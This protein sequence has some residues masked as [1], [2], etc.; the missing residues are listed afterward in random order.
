MTQR[1]GR[2]K[3]RAARAAVDDALAQAASYRQAAQDANDIANWH[4]RRHDRAAALLGEVVERITRAVTAESALLPVDVMPARKSRRE[5]WARNHPL[6]RDLD[7]F[8]AMS[9][10]AEPL[11]LDMSE[12]FVRLQRLVATVEQH[13]DQFRTLIRFEDYEDGGPGKI[14]GRAVW[15]SRD[16]LRRI[17]LMGGD[18]LRLVDDIAKQLIELPKRTT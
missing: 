3:R 13:P 9:A 1:F 2:N 12:D 7:G 14:S 4:A 11:K 17:G 10:V 8:I 16:A 15:I 5:P 18:R 6:P